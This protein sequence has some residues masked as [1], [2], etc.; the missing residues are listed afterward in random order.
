MKAF[1]LSQLTPGNVESISAPLETLY[2]LDPTSEEGLQAKIYLDKLKKGEP[3]DGG[4]VPIDSPY[5]YD[6]TAKHFFMLYFPKGAADVNESKI[7]VSN[8]NAEFYRNDALSL[9]DAPLGV[10]GQVLV[11][12]SFSDLTKAKIYLTS[13]KSP[14]AQEII[15]TMA[16]DYEICL[17]TAKN[18]SELFKLKE[19]ETYFSFY[20]ANY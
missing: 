10:D 9:Q 11:V 1:S 4:Q 17:I 18:F 3:I 15:G 2:A 16:T 20:S 13:F 12:R 5:I 7:K 6:A 8:F 19:F 14:K